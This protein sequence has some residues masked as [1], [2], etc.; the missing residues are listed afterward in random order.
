M[1]KKI[2]LTFLILVVF[3]GAWSAKTASTAT[4]CLA[5]TP[6]SSQSEKDFCKK[7]LAKIEAELQ[8]LLNKQEIQKHQSGTI[9][10][11]INYLNSQIAS[12][13]SKI[14]SRSYAI[15]QLQ[16]EIKEKVST[17]GALS[18][19]IDRQYESIAQLIR[20]TNDFDNINMVHLVLAD[21]TI[22][23]LYND[24][25][26]YMSIKS[27]VKDSVDELRGLKTNTEEEKKSL[28]QKQSAEANA[29]QEL[30]SS[31]QKVAESEKEKQ[32]LLAISKQKEAQYQAL[33]A[34]KK[35][36]A[37]QIRA[38]LFPLRD[39]QAI[40]FGTALSYAEQASKKT[41]VRPAYILAIL[42]Q[43]SNLGSNVGT[44]NRP[45]DTRTW[46]D[47]MPG[48]NDNSWRDDQSAFERITSRLG[49]S[50][51]GVPLS[52]PLS[53]G[54]WGGAMGPSQFI[55]Y[56]WELYSSRIESLLG[57]SVADPWNPLHAIS[58]TAL[59]AMD[60]GAGAQTY[61]AEREAACKYYSGRS[62]T[63]PNVRNA[64]YGDAVMSLA[65]SIQK[66][67]DFLYSN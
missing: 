64:F 34:Q 66:D 29:K 44:C 31:R 35:A 17:I 25:E 1:Q 24:L 10:G 5:L 63:A 56:T 41:G 65:S 6:N 53:S 7:E 16:V 27:A 54:G 9:V 8:E 32:Q 49:I 45:G 50:P 22:S 59:Y 26:S 12:L 62:C 40:P 3:F 2:L 19:K 61:N 60:L 58:A 21:Q 42:K 15:A 57:T 33:A 55:P 67:I 43:E 20:N 48:P 30:E 52:C 37:D 36:Q 18:T 51:V 46:R 13:R 14:K 4:D 28:E 11:D 23:E 38:A 47:I 39:S